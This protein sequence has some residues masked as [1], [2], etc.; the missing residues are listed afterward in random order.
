MSKALQTHVF[1]RL[2]Y[3]QAT[4]VAYSFNHKLQLIQFSNRK[5]TFVIRYFNQ[6]YTAN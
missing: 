2:F 3:A 5:Q 1:A 6:I 4:S